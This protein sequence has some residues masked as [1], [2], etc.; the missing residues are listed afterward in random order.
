MNRLFP[1]KADPKKIIHIN[2]YPAPPVPRKQ[3]IKA[4]QGVL[5]LLGNIEETKYV[6]DIFQAVSGGA[7]RR[8]F[9]TFSGSPY[10]KKVLNEDIKVEDILNQRDWLRSLP[11][12]T[13]G[14]CYHDM[15]TSKNFAVDGLLVA[16]EHAGIDINA[17]TMFEAYRRYFIHFEVTHDLW[18]VLTGYDTDPLGEICLLYFYRAQWPDTG[19]KILTGLGRLSNQIE[20]PR[21]TSLFKKAYKEGYQNGLA[22]KDLLCADVEWML[23]SPL[24]AVRRELNIKEPMSYRKIPYSIKSN[25][26]GGKSTSETQLEPVF[27]VGVFA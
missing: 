20:R 19:L 3:P 26:K 9:E 12:G 2:G 8:G 15:I 4:V 6:Y 18:H 10:G 23:S 27:E 13:V 7:Y 5:K 22:A 17:P 16:A 14:R 1:E 24:E 25:L 11:K 21:Q